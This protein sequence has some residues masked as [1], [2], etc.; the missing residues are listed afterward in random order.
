MT[1][2][3]LHPPIHTL[4]PA[5]SPATTFAALSMEAWGLPRECAT[6]IPVRLGVWGADS[7]P[8]CSSQERRMRGLG[9]ER[10]EEGPQHPFAF[11]LSFIHRKTQHCCQLT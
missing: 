8:A 2:G 6:C 5:P 7:V 1:F 11:V 3:C 10:R 4:P 9:G